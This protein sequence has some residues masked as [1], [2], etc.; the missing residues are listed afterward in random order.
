M[1]IIHV[2][3]LTAVV[4]ASTVPPCAPHAVVPVLRSY[5]TS[6]AE[7]SALVR[8]VLQELDTLQVGAAEQRLASAHAAGAALA[9]P[10]ADAWKGLVARLR[11]THLVDQRDWTALLLVDAASVQ[12]LPW[13]VELLQGLGH[14]RAA[15]ARQDPVLFARAAQSARTL[16]EMGRMAADAEILRAW[17]LVQAAIA[18]GQYERD[19]M[20]LL[21]EEAAH[22]EGT[23][24]D[25]FGET[26][27]PIVLA[28][29]LE[30]DLLLQ[31]DRYVMAAESYRAVLA[32]RPD[33]VH[34]WL[35]LAEACRREGLEAQ[36]AAAA[37]EARRRSRAPTHP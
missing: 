20:R 7:A 15:W 27:V 4:Q 6:A 36:A 9:G 25:A 16:E 12:G 10:H 5:E 21:L 8:C 30:A 29:E 37:A 13:A 3:Y 22:L 35:G 19:E 31:T 17:M 11:A 33:R 28:R 32:R 18:G 26:F 34:S 2:L 1:T 14:A 23:L 24:S